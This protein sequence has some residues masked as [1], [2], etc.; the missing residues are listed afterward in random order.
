MNDN[1]IVR[2]PPHN[3][4]AEQSV[5]GSMILDENRIDEVADILSRDDFY[6]PAYGAVFEAIV[7]LKRKGSPA[8]TVTILEKLHKKGESENLID[9]KSVS[10]IVMT[11]PTSVRIMDYAKIVKEKSLLRKLIKVCDDI[12]KDCYIASD[13]ADSIFDSVEKQVFQIINNRNG[14]LEYV[15]MNRIILNVIDRIEEA[16]RNGGK[17]TGLPTGF[18]DLDTILNGMDAG[19]LILIAARPAMG[20]TAFALNIVHYL[21]VHKQIPCAFFSLEMDPE[22]LGARLVALDAGVNSEKIKIGEM[23]DD[24]WDKLIESTDVMS[25]APIYVF[26]K[27]NLTISDIRTQCMQLKLREG[28]KLIV[29]DYLQ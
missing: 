28:L 3:K 11:V 21:S 29:L 20:K 14:S 25:K 10:E 13:D 16:A 4:S 27:P 1:H 2:I 12:E 19:Q 26:N 15:P 18:K 5:I 6:V 24:D 8:D 22:E 7:D 23:P 17:P 9:A